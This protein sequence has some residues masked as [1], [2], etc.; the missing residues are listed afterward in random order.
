MLCL[1]V[2]NQTVRIHETLRLNGADIKRVKK[3][4]SLGV[5]VDEGLNWEEQF[6]TIKGKVS[7]GLTS[8]KKLKI[9]SHNLS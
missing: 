3:T 2:R 9:S 8:L 6:K 7:G 4:K 1:T 5:I